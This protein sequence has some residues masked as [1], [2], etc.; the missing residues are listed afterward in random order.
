[1][2]DVINHRTDEYG[3]SVENRCRFLME[4]V[5]AVVAA[6]GASHVAV[7]ISP[8]IDHIDAMDSDPLNLGLA[9]IERLN[10][11]Q[12]R[13]GSKLAYLHV[14]QP[15]FTAAGTQKFGEGDEEAELM[16]AC[17]KAYQ[18]TFMSSGGFT[19]ELGMKAVADGDADLISYGRLFISNPDLVFRFKKNAPLNHYDRA[20]FYTSD[21]VVGYTD[22][23]F[24]RE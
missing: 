13:L 14:T 8:A 20:T 2:K 4:I 19:R 6:I 11:L 12:D 16:G 3:G 10:T 22:Y 17:R 9:V 24:L 5:Q 21:P 18:G 1:M 23:P 15:R 7:R